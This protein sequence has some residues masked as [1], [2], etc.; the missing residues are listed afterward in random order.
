M[1]TP[2]TLIIDLAVGYGGSSSRVLGLLRG[3]SKQGIALA[4]L[5]HGAVV[6]AAQNEG[7]PVYTLGANKADP[8]ILPRLVHVIRSNG[9]E[10]LDTQNIQSKFWA[11]L[12]AGLTRTSLI[13]TI[14]S[15]YASEH[16]QSAV[17]SRIKGQIYTGLELLT[18]WNLDLYITVSEKD[19]QALLRSKI[20]EE[21]IELIYNA[22]DLDITK[23]SGDSDW[24]R[25]KFNLPSESLIC[26]AVG[27]LVPVKGYDVLIDA[28]KQITTQVP[29]LICLIVGEGECKDVLTQ[30]IQDSGL[31]NQVRLTGYQD[32]DTV[33]SIL[34]SSDIF[35]MP[36]RYEGT[37][38]A[39]LEAAALG[40]PIIA[41]ASGGIPELVTDHEHALLVQPNDPTALAKSILSL[42][43]DRSYGQ[44]LG[45]K[46]KQRI[47]TIFNMDTQIQRTFLAYQK[48]FK[49]HNETKGK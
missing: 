32:R 49:K 33:L 31:G 22:V 43:T 5:D 27:R 8:R 47:Q 16:G 24:L 34:K 39:L 20:P 12:A 17:K 41:S 29:Q 48:A 9:F 1:G 36:S 45:I 7:L 37:P 21:T 30:Q 15:W 38:I 13:S 25:K 14:N 44:A 6:L 11:S 23:I 26:V 4:G 46:A 3:L 19:R 40:L 2:R 18:N 10:V 35:V 42:C 28:M